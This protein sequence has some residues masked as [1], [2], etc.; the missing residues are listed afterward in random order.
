MKQFI[1]NNDIT[2]VVYCKILKYDGNTK[3][4]IIEDQHYF[5]GIRFDTS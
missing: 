1:R 4:G 3:I 5:Y 2:D